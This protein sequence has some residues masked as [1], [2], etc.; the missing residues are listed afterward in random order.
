MSM[1][2]VTNNNNNNNN[3]EDEN[4]V[5]DCPICLNAMSISDISYPLVCPTANC[6]DFNRIC[7]HCIQGMLQSEADGYQ[8]ASDGSHQVKFCVSCPACRT[9]YNPL[10]TNSSK[11]NNSNNNKRGS[12]KSSPDYDQSIIHH[13]IL[14]RR[15]YAVQLLLDINDSDL[16]AT[17]LS[18]KHDFLQ[19]TPDLSLQKIQDA[20]VLFIK[21]LKDIQ[22]YETYENKIPKLDW[23]KLDEAL[24]MLKNSSL[25]LQNLQLSTS[26]SNGS[27]INS[28]NSNG[29]F[30]NNSNN[31]AQ[32]QHQ[33]NSQQPWRDVTLFYGVLQDVM[34]V[35]EQEFLTQLF[36]SGQP[37]LVA[38]AAHIVHGILTMS[39]T[40]S[41]S[42][43]TSTQSQSTLSQAKKSTS[44]TTTTKKAAQY[45]P[46]K[47]A[48]LRGRFPLPQHMPLC[49]ALPVYDPTSRSPL[50][51]FEQVKKQQSRN[52]GK[53]A[54]Q[55]PPIANGSDNDKSNTQGCTTTATTSSSSSE[56]IVARVHGPAG[57]LGLRRGDVVTH[58]Q[59]GCE[60][61]HNRADWDAHL[62]QLLQSSSTTT[63]TSP[64]SPTAANLS[65]NNSNNS[66]VTFVVVNANAQT[67]NALKERALQMQRE[68]KHW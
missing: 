32:A 56:L 67:A 10:A 61:M 21:Y 33:K 6:N 38:Q 8:Q 12:P 37:D 30:P 43:S 4:A 36:T 47:L 59:G 29:D 28:S 35:S 53:G 54:E 44:T 11:A 50:L 62:L 16:S 18:L 5:V 60:A 27:T 51:S 68:L 23:A 48:Q 63:T 34:T 17:Q 1:A 22:K 2:L 49:V 45:S 9:R 55:Q 15:V 13:V 57:R 40:Q 46:K 52:H 3:K 39:M 41:S 24:I 25:S 65:K 19:H 58:V 20:A 42:Y 66:L 26:N 7:L 64:S 31:K 14:L